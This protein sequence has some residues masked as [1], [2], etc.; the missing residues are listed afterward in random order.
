MEE[1]AMYDNIRRHSFM[2][3]RVADIILRGLQ[4]SPSVPEIP[5]RELVVAGALMHDIAKTKC[6][7]E[8]CKHADIGRDMCRELGLYTIGEI[9]SNHV[10]LSEFK[11]EAYRQGLFSAIELVF[12]A[13]KR[14]KHD[15]VVPLSERLDYI[16]DKYSN[17]EAVREDYI[18]KNFEQ[19]QEVEE[20]LFARLDFSPDD[21]I[22][23]LP[24]S[25]SDLLHHLP[26]E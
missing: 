9:V 5:A 12:Y 3:A 11:R 8:G 26:E 2:V 10:V 1:F 23:F 20:H 6:I 7:R 21:I 15:V 18:R 17:N 19:C 4:S 16:I 24:S 13:D 14:V 25:P 22:T